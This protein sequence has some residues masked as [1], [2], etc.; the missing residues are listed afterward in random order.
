MVI[1]F[2]LIAQVS[3]GVSGE[4]LLNRQSLEEFGH[5]YGNIKY[6]QSPFVLSS[7]IIFQQNSSTSGRILFFAPQVSF[8]KS[9]INLDLIYFQKT[10]HKGIILGQSGDLQFKRL[11]YLRGLSLGFELGGFSLELLGGTPFIFEYDNF[12]YRLDNDTTDLLRVLN[13]GHRKGVTDFEASYVRLNRRNMPQSD[14]FQEIYGF[15]AGLDYSSL[16]FELNVARKW[17]V[18]PITYARIKGFGVNPTLNFFL[19]KLTLSF[20][21]IYYD[22]LNFW[23]YNQPPVITEKEILPNGGNSDKGLGIYSSFSLFNL[24]WEVGLASVVELEE[25]DLFYPDTGKAFQ[26]SYVK[27][28]ISNVILNLDL[29]LAREYYRRV[30]PEYERL[31]TYY[32]EGHGKTQGKIPVEVFAKISKNREDSLNYYLSEFALG[33]ELPLRITPNLRIE[34]ASKKV[35]RF[36]NEKLWPSLEINYR[37]ENGNITVAFGKQR[38]G[39]VC[40]GGMCRLVPS[41]DGFKLGVNLGY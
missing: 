19:E 37:F 24:Y 41:F 9:P 28:E 29:K 7:D 39:L 5:L 6:A 20:S 32:L 4:Y 23:N 22:S 2:Y 13:F 35:P 27:T 15:R 3:F 8:N 25:K 10:L 33:L 11:K 21:G 1:L 30:E 40:S 38:G 18:D 36:E 26:E 16:G 34:Y 31:T 14:A 17:G 12:S